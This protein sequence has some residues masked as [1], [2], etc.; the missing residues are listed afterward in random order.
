MEE[1]H[2]LL[3]SL[4]RAQ[5]RLLRNYL[6]C[7][8]S[9]G[10]SDA[11]TLHLVE[12]LLKAREAPSLATCSKKI[13]GVEPDAKITKLKSRLKSKILDALLSDINIDKKGLL[14]KSELMPLKL[15]KKLTQF[16]YLLYKQGSKPIGK[17]LL[18]E[19]IVNSKQY[20]F[21]P[22]V[23]EGLRYKKYYQGFRIGEKEFDTISKELSFYEECNQ[24][25]NKAVDYYY[26]KT[27]KGNFKKSIDFK[28]SQVFLRNSIVDLKRDYEHTKSAVVGYY[29]KYLEQSYF[30][31][32]KNYEQAREA[33]LEQLAIVNNNVS[34]Y[35]K[36]RVGIIYDN[37]AQYDILLGEYDKAVNNA[38]AAQKHILKKSANYFIS[39][40]IEFEALFYS[41]QYAK[42]KAISA[43]LINAIANQSG[44]FR[45]DIYKF[46][47]AN[48]LYMLGDFKEALKMLSERLEV[49]KDKAGW[50]IGIRILT[51]LSHIELQNYDYV[52]QLIEGLRRHI[53]RQGKLS[54]IRERDRLIVKAL[55]QMNKRGFAPGQVSEKEM[56]ILRQLASDDKKYKWEALTPELIPFHQWAAQKYRLNLNSDR[57]T[58]KLARKAKVLN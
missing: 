39:K 42:A 25:V 31:N 4:S 32:S 47:R 23:I 34:V 27:I 46:F 14:D 53:D 28:N 22:G 7:F 36:Q 17:Q 12:L 50:E 38:V 18:D 15:R 40:E 3:H 29:L 41:G 6:T 52:S 45:Y 37:I 33:C 54:D 10:E 48:S 11:K 58:A 26:L 2:S 55:Q 57:T 43:T 5:I 49:S 56:D 1:L 9:R 13:Y 20:E 8:S 44:D 16:T 21:Y 24:A 51:I 30:E 19:I 35:R